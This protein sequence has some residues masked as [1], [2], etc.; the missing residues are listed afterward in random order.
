MNG[1]HIILANPNW[2]P[3]MCVGPPEETDLQNGCPRQAQLFFESLHF[4]RARLQAVDSEHSRKEVEAVFIVSHLAPNDVLHF[5]HLLA[6]GRSWE[7][8]SMCPYYQDRNWCQGAGFQDRTTRGWEAVGHTVRR[9]SRWLGR[10]EALC[11]SRTG[12]L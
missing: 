5:Q 12:T 10:Q 3:A 1:K 7:H 11:Q 2:W 4:W 6:S 9:R 8:I